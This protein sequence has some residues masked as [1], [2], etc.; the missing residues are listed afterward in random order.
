VPGLVLV[1]ARLGGHAVDR[2]R[3]ARHAQA[4]LRLRYAVHDC[5]HAPVDRL[6]VEVRARIEQARIHVVMLHL[7]ARR[8]G[9]C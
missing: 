7:I 9:V 4:E 6:P 8:A 5:A 1:D 2:F 3:L